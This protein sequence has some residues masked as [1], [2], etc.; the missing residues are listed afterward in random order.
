[1]FVRYSITAA[2]EELSTR[3]AVD[4]PGG[5]APRYNAAPTHLL[6]VITNDSQKGVSFFYWGSPPV[7]ANKKPLGEKIINMKAEM[8]SEKQVAM[9]KLK[10]RR[11]IIPADGFFEWK[12]TGK[13]TSIPYRFTLKDKNLFAMAGVW[14]EFDD[15]HGEMFHTFS[16]I[17]TPANASVSAIGER[18]P[19]ILQPEYEKR[20]LEGDDE[21]SMMAQLVPFAGQLDHYSVSSGVNSPDRNDKFIVQPAPPADQFG[22]L[23]LFD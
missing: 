10:E 19:V 23:S 13:K 5:Y 21:Q 3:F 17:T 14:E 18:M 12:R 15:Q 20:W 9:K 16:V 2:S 1:M 11:C 8:L 6:P 7:M 4:V 22:N